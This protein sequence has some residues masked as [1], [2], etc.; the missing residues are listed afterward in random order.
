MELREALAGIR[1]A[2]DPFMALGSLMDRIDADF[3]ALTGELEA[4]FT[5]NGCDRPDAVAATLMKMQFF[6]RLQEEALELEALLEDEQ[7]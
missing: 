3:A 5:G 6:R 4:G 1:T 7:V 2:V